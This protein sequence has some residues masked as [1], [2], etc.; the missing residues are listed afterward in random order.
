MIAPKLQR[1]R[2]DARTA[3]P[4]RSSA[5]RRAGA[6]AALCCLTVALDGCFL[7]KYVY[8]PVLVANA[9]GDSTTTLAATR[10]HVYHTDEYEIYG[11]S[12]VSVGTA[13]RQ[14]DR[15][16]REFVKHFGVQAPPMAIVVADSE[17]AISPS[18]AGS[19]G[20]RRIHTFVYVRP[21][22]LRDLEGVAPDTPEDEIWP[23]SGR[24]ARELFSA[25]IE[26]RRNVPPEVESHSHPGDYHL[27]PF[28]SWYVDA[29]VALLG[30]P[31]TPDRI[32]DFLRD[33]LSDVAPVATLL[34]MHPPNPGVADT[35]AASRE[36]RALIG[37]EGVALTLFLAEREGPRVVGRLADAF[38]AG[39]TARDV[40][41]QSH[42]APQNDRDFERVWRNW[43]RE[44]YGR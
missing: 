30:D 4:R 11:P 3:N 27:D 5:R 23:V 20:K 24:V 41:S 35:I 8:R 43:V 32:M 9:I 28:P 31:G 29:V 17:F 40:V 33:R 21:H 18:D 12:A 42:H 7:R 15:A 6:I 26:Q 22:N 19:F 36:R 14:V 13:E 16:Y 37:A 34:D 44:E 1:P 38:L 39:G 2:G 10:L 25:Y